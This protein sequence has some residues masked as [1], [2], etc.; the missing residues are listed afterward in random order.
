MSNPIIFP[1]T[2]RSRRAHPCSATC[3]SARD[4]AV[5][6]AHKLLQTVYDVDICSRKILSVR[7]CN[8]K[9]RTR[10]W[11]PQWIAA[12]LWRRAHQT[13]QEGGN[14]SSAGISICTTT[15]ARP[16]PPP[17][18]DII[19][20]GQLANDRRFFQTLSLFVSQVSTAS[21]T[22][23]TPPKQVRSKTSFQTLRQTGRRSVCRPGC[24]LVYI[25]GFS[26]EVL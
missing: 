22:C 3:P 19:R 14:P 13:H 12:A 4:K 2:M 15:T 7:L 6:S 21:H 17:R 20:L 5:L 26:C 18:R 25:C 10:D 16:L 11:H 23:L 24:G 9:W 1:P 8:P